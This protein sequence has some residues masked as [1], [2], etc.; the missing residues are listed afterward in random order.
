[1][2]KYGGPGQDRDDKIIRRMLFARLI[3]KTRINPQTEYLKL[4]PWLHE[5]VSTLRYTHID[6][7]F[8]SALF[9]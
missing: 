7:L 6:Y 1:M 5:R 2:E 4:I 9:V 8:P 3:T